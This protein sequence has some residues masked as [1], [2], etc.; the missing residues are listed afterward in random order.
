MAWLRTG[1]VAVTNGST[2]VTGTGTGFAANTRVGDAFVGPDG[3]YYELGNVASD[4]VISIIPAYQGATVSGASYAIMPVQ[5]YQK[6]LADQVRDWVNTYGAKMASLGTTGNYDVLPV[7]KGGTGGSTQA[8]ARNGLGLLPAATT[9]IGT[10]AGNIMA[11]GAGGWLGSSI[12]DN[13]NANNAKPT[14]LYSLSSATNAPYAALQLFTS[15]WGND[16]RWQAQFGMGISENRFFGRSILKD[17]TSATSWVEFYHTGN[18]TRGSGGA[19]SAA[20]PIVRIAS[21][22]D[23]QRSDLQEQAFEPAGAWGV[24]NDEARGVLVERL[25]VGEYRVTGSLGLALE[26]WRTQDPCSPDGGRILGITESDQ[27]VD[28]AVTIRLFKERWVLTEDGEMMPGKGAPMDVP[29]NSWI[30]V[31][32]EMPQP[33]TPPPPATLETE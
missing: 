20:S 30:D 14:G 27:A 6:G 10:A 11:V 2:T 7:S 26:G 17:Q 8:D 9:P 5:G 29:L 33:E 15:D 25:G 24:A 1:T 16:P 19:L 21:V 31:R 22:A 13:G 23:S 32:L 28:G 18:T 3:R 4:T 12:I